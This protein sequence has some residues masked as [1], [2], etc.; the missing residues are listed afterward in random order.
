MKLYIWN[1][2]CIVSGQKWI[3][4]KTNSVW[5]CIISGH[6]VLQLLSADASETDISITHQLE[7]SSR[8]VSELKLTLQ[9]V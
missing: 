2:L 5:P 4:L 7:Q 6:L 3:E 9:V 1:V 8:A